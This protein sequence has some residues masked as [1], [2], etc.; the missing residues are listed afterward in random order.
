MEWSMGDHSKMIN[1]TFQNTLDNIL[2]NELLSQGFTQEENPCVSW[3]KESFFLLFFPSDRVRKKRPLARIRR[4]V[5]PKKVRGEKKR[6]RAA[7][8]WTRFMQVERPSGQAPLGRNTR[9][10]AVLWPTECTYTHVSSFSLPP[11]FILTI[12]GCVHVR[13]NKKMQFTVMQCEIKQAEET[14]T[15]IPKR[16]FQNLCH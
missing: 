11:L 12:T 14:E 4:K 7:G 8:S 9:T 15:V 10:Y 3:P 2:L 13:S 5:P 16:T 6:K 1:L